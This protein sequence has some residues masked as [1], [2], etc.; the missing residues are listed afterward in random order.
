MVHGWGDGL[1]FEDLP[2]LYIPDQL[3]FSAAEK[4]LGTIAPGPAA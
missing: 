1:N 4:I 3:K 2:F